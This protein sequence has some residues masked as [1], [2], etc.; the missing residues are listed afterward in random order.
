MQEKNCAL[1]WKEVMTMT[2]HEE[3]ERVQQAV[4][5]SL[6]Q[7]REDP[8]L[9]QRV[10]AHAKGEEPVKRKISLALVLG[11]VGILAL[12]GTAYALFSSQVAEFFGRHWNQEL[13]ARLQG[14]K[15][16]QIGESVTVDDVIISLDE[17]VYRD[18]GLYG[19]GTVRPVREEDV[20]FPMETTE[21]MIMAQE[22][23]FH[24]EEDHSGP[25]AEAYD[26]AMAMVNK[27]KA[28]GG[29]MLSVQSMPL[30]IGVDD[31]TML[32]PGSIGFY[33]IDNEDGS[34]TYSFEASD[35]FVVNEGTTYQVLMESVV[36]QIQENG[37]PVEGTQRRYEW[38]ISCT[39]VFMTSQD[40]ETGHSASHVTFQNENSYEVVTPEAYRETGGMPLYQAV[41]TDFTRELHPE[42]F[43]ET[44]IKERAGENEIVFSDHAI[45]AVS[46][47]AL[48]YD[49]YL[50]DQY[51]ESPSGA[52]VRLVWIRDWA[53]HRGE[54]R[55]EKTALSGITLEEAKR[56]AESMIT[57]LGLDSNRY[58][59]EFALD[60]SL[61]RIQAMGAIYEQA[62]VDGE[63]LTD[64]DW[65]P[66]DYAAI[67]SG[68]EGFYLEY[69]PEQIDST[70]TGG[71]YGLQFYVNSRGIVFAHLRNQFTMGGL[72]ETP[73][74]LI[75]HEEAVERFKKEIR[76]SRYGKD[77][78]IV[79]VLRAVLTYEPVRAAAAENGMVFVPAWTIVYQDQ[80]AAR[81][82]FE[83]YALF[84][85][86]DGTLIDASFQ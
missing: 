77:E 86:V 52:I 42:W 75:T 56:Q 35:G 53:N 73:E 16:A 81:H 40:S 55:L 47:E 22:E 76:Q 37:Y 23:D 34:V 63:L 32:M 60:M 50:D 27:A 12:I 5:H 9:A 84:N 64:D 83:C 65:T 15:I 36:Q 31:G 69:R 66:Y 33:D 44:G 78:H 45:L 58:K 18:R 20:L 8:W 61:E 51:T 30:K 17:I 2:L 59:L 21:W 3:Q 67:P 82:N 80:Q 68:E 48:F 41:E 10:L 46:P 25:A 38:T 24:L 39:P 71:R 28:S 57:R 54:F 43:N 26:A 72:A 79:S 6:S 14:G 11:I 4:S 85:A 1:L 7:V 74:K 49:E 29:K 62:I 19:V 70:N 13:G